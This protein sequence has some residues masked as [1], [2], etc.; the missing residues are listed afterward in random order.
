MSGCPRLIF[1]ICLFLGGI[2]ANIF[3]FKI[4]LKFIFL[5]LDLC[6]GLFVIFTDADLV[7]NPTLPLKKSPPAILILK[8]VLLQLLW[9][10]IG[11]RAY[12]SCV[13]P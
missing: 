5:I 6:R 4:R 9:I 8:T 7:I 1:Y 10:Y 2:F 3:T 12:D 11:H 13:L